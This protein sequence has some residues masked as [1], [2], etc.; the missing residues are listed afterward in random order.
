MLPQMKLE[1]ILESFGK[2]IAVKQQEPQLE[3]K[4]S[5]DIILEF[6]SYI[7][8]SSEFKMNFLVF[9]TAVDRKDSIDV[10]YCTRSIES[11]EQLLFSVNV[12]ADRPELPSVTSIWKAANWDERETFDL[13]GIT[14]TGHPNLKRILLPD[15]WEGHPLRKS[16]PL[17]ARPKKVLE[18]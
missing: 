10:V 5:R 12:P 15:N 13:F 2:E 8:N 4:V 3:L 16:V 17:K 6:A 1:K 18:Q 11:K 7:K 14:F 9:L